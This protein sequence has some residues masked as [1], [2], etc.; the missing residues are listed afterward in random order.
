MDIKSINALT[1]AARTDSEAL[2]E[3]YQLFFPRLYNFIFGRVKNQAVADDIVSQ[4]FE[5]ML[6]KLD[7]YN[8][9]KGAFSTWLM[10]IGLNQ[11]TDYY[12][13]APQQ[14]EAVWDDFF[15][16]AADT[17]TPEASILASEGNAELLRALDTL[18]ER[19]RR[20][21]TLKYW[22]DMG[23]AEIAEL[24]GL[25]ANNVGVI[26]HRALGKLR[27]ALGEAE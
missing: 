9:E 23:N 15:D 18:P 21:I 22:G 4:T 1:V 27:K 8:P 17:P 20:I 3:L 2:T 19:E 25:K 7:T 16:P 14:K 26:L 5:K 10:R 12:R 6:V 13:S 24:M 11:V